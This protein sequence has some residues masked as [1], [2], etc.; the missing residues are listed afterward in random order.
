MIKTNNDNRFDIELKN[1][2]AVENELARLLGDCKLEVKADRLWSSTGNVAIEYEYNG[3][4]SGIRTTESDWYII[5][6]MDGEVIKKFIGIRTNEIIDLA[7]CAVKFGNNKSG[8]DDM[9]SKLALVKVG[10]LL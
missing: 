1:G 7:R 8:G 3:K 9:K 10:D 2:Q 4:P 6:L 5:A